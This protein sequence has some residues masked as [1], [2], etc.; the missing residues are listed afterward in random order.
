MSL[1]GKFISGVFPLLLSSPREIHPL[2]CL[3]STEVIRVFFE[4]FVPP[5]DLPTSNSSAGNKH[6]WYFFYPVVISQ[7]FMSIDLISAHKG[8]IRLFPTSNLTPRP[9][10]C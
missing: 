4:G 3:V 5:G 1:L 10:D 6:K 8:A 9:A 2:G 7:I